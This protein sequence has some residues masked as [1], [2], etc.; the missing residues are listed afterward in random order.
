M[1]VSFC[2]GG[3][4]SAEERQNTMG[5][6]PWSFI[7]K[8]INLSLKKSKTYLKRGAC[9]LVFDDGYQE[10]LDHVLP[11][12]KKY[13]LKASFAFATKPQSIEKVA[14]FACAPLA[15][16]PKLKKAGHEIASHTV[17][18][19]NL[20]FYSPQQLDT[21][22]KTSQAKLKAETIIYPGGAYDQKVINRAKNYYQFGRGVEEGLNPIPPLNFLTLKTFV[23]RQNTKWSLLNRQ[24]QKAHKQNK[25]L[26]ESY[27]LVSKKDRNYRF[28]VTP[29][30]L[31]KHLLK[32]LKYNL[33]IAP[34]NQV[35]HYIL[36]K[37]NA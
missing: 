29:N 31:E 1:R 7:F 24:A 20:T 19:K 30:D 9:S 18:H 4:R 8:M 14:G 13:D 17:E 15:L 16:L 34:L 33:W 3:F 37:S 28:T 27:H 32:L 35:A 23:L 11:L 26:I 36:N 6:S 22:L 5:V 25:W 12:L 21:E 10:T 2:F